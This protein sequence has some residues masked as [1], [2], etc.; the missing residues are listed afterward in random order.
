MA[1]YKELDY[2]MGYSMNYIQLPNNN[3]IFPRH[4]EDINPLCRYLLNH[5]EYKLDCLS[6]GKN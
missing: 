4:F 2:A 3:T 6:Y 1:L 5:V